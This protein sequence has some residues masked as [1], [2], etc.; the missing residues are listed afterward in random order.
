M[1]YISLVIALIC[2]LVGKLIIRDMLHPAN[3][4]S[5]VWVSYIMLT[6]LAGDMFYDI[7]VLGSFV[8]SVGNICFV[9]ASVAMYYYFKGVNRFINFNH[10]NYRKEKRFEWSMWIGLAV[11]VISLPF[12]WDKIQALA[13]GSEQFWIAVRYNSIENVAESQT[14]FDLLDNVV[15]FTYI[16]SVLSVWEYD[17]T[18]KK[19]LFMVA[20]IV[21]CLTFN[22]MDA[23]RSG[24]ATLFLSVIGIYW[25]KRGYI[26]K[27]VALISGVLFMVFFSA[28]AIMVGKGNVESDR[29]IAENIPALADNFMHYAA[30]GL[31]AFDIAA[32]HPERVPPTWDPFR[33]IKIHLNKFGA[34]FHVDNLHA[35]FVDVGPNRITNVYTLYFSYFGSY[36]WIGLILFTMLISIYSSLI[37]RYAKMGSPHAVMQFAIV[38]SGISLS[39]FNEGFMLNIDPIIKSFLVT[40]IIYGMPVSLQKLVG[41][42]A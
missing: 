3:L 28:V 42:R 7:S 23:G 29:S 18:S 38:F 27:K 15:P 33:T 14:R 37:Y 19:R 21:A 34:G 31:P 5:L 8:F 4:F 1:I 36:G 2:L 9:I 11:V 25:L 30:S 13:G 26:P 6:V 35:E 40:V 41:S 22:I 39:G 10:Y 17:G 24:V 20:S 16:M 12:Y 32:T